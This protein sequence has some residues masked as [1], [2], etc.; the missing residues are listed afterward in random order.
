LRKKAI[1][2][3]KG[4]TY[5]LGHQTWLM[6]IIN[7]T[8]DSFS[9][10]GLY[11]NGDQAIQ[12]GME[13]VSQGADIIDIGGESTRPGSE[14]VS[15]EEECSRVL[16]VISGLRKM[17]DAWISIDTTK[18]AVAS[19]ALDAGADFINDIS[20][21]RFDP[22]MIPLAA[23]KDVPVILMHMKGT[24]K[25]MQDAPFYKDV[26]R[27]INA[28]FEERI[29]GAVDGGIKREKII[30]DPGI[31][32]G[33]RLEDNLVLINNLQTFHDHQRPMLVGV[34][35]KSFIGK[36]LNLDVENRLEGT[37]ASALLSIVNGAHILR[38]HDVEAIKRAV[39][40]AESIMQE[41]PW[42]ESLE[43][44]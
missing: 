35:R 28:F 36:T 17:T 29:A 15:P 33:K 11:C 12:R 38:I 9:D 19:A 6:G 44:R 31:G 39:H 22:K 24:P 32:F 2:E 14:S 20:A 10:G 18:S 34:S 7:V 1:L 42:G 40:M 23:E 21:L 16:P 5:T 37:I 30:L 4:K 25:T 3:I 43:K 13:L 27:E 26:L 41:K 8:P